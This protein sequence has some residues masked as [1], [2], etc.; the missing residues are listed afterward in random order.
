VRAAAARDPVSDSRGSRLPH[1]S[2][3]GR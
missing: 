3:A 2:R 1:H